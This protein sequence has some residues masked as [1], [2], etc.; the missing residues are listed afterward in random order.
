MLTLSGS[1]TTWYPVSVSDL[2]AH[3][4]QLIQPLS[5]YKAKQCRGLQKNI[6]YSLQH[7]E[8]IARARTDINM[9]AVIS[10]QNAKMFIIITCSV[11]EAIFFYLLRKSGKAAKTPWQS[12]KKVTGQSFKDN[13]EKIKR[14]DCEIF[15]NVNP[16]IYDEMT[17]DAM[18]KRVEGKD[19][20][21]LTNDFYKKLPHL[22]TLRNR[23]HLHILKDDTETD[24]ISISESDYSLAKKTLYLLLT[25]SLFPVTKEGLFSY[26]K[27]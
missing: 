7:L 21:S 6:A 16:E 2:E 20:A 3:L 9:S 10:N 4:K 18:C 17:F 25:S 13:D 12:V 1:Q 27:G 5:D 8:F 23:V 26:L 24:Y 11:M 15:E 14:I 19:L 22:R